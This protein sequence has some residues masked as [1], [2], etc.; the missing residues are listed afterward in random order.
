MCIYV[1]TNKGTGL[2]KGQLLE[3][4]TQYA[5]RWTL[6]CHAEY[7][8]C[9]WT[10]ENRFIRLKLNMKIAIDYIDISIDIIVR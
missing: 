3:D 10:I 9:G 7:L 8:Y 5:N 1:T 6:T 4:D 2:S